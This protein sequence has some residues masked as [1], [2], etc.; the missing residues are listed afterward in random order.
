MARPRFFKGRLVASTNTLR[1]IMSKRLE[2]EVRFKPRTPYYEVISQRVLDVR[3]E[4]FPRV[5]TT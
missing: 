3:R 5:T 2:V 1:S 4:P